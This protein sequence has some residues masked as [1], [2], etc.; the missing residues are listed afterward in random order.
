MWHRFTG[1]LNFLF[2]HL[3]MLLH[4]IPL[5]YAGSKEIS[6]IQYALFMHLHLS[7]YQ[8]SHSHKFVNKKEFT[9]I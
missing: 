5:I 8:L 6:K 7:A 4:V 3:M 1:L 9:E 2:P